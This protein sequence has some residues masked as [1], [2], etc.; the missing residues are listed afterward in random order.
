MKIK[1]VKEK[2]FYLIAIGISIFLLF[3]FITTV[4]IGY[5]TNNLCYLFK[6]E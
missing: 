1:T 4:W 3:F 5:E 2:L 6:S